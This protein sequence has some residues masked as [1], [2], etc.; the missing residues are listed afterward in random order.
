MKPVTWLRIS[1]WA[2]AVADGLVGVLILVPDRMGETEFRYPMGLAASLMFGWTALLLWADRKPLER[3]GV[4]PLTVAVILGLLASG[5]YAV[6]AG[7]FPIGHILPTTLLGLVVIA[8]FVFSYLK[9][10]RAARG[11]NGPR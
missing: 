1:Y 4:L 8:L 2:G 3:R 9:A 6:A 10:G 5:F 7:I 11:A